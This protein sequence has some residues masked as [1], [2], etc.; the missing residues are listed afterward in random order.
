MDKNLRSALCFF[1]AALLSSNIYSMT[2]DFTGGS[3]S[4]DPAFAFPSL[5]FSNGDV[6][7]TASAG[8]QSS[9]RDTV[10]DS[11][12][13]IWWD[14]RG[15]GVTDLE[16]KTERQR[17]HCKF[18]VFGFCVSWNY[19][20]TV[21]DELQLAQQ[22]D[23]NTRERD[24]IVLE[25]DQE[26]VVSSV[27]L[28]FEDSDDAIFYTIDAG[29]L[30]N[31][32]EAEIGGPNDRLFSLGAQT[33]DV[34]AVGAGYSNHFFGADF[35]PD[36]FYLASI[37][38]DRQSGQSSVSNE[39]PEPPAYLLFVVGIISLYSVRR[40]NQKRVAPDTKT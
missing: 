34:F 17:T 22:D 40:N 1:T 26:V 3:N 15:L 25:F 37:T 8:R 5:D 38:F 24:A 20:V 12:R 16:N 33:G 30:S 9:D 6:S 35:L 13:F 7:V 29:V 31:A 18:S 36:A 19:E 27:S 4:Q 10:S 23:V 21:L 2:I 14:A 28:H 39:I 11:E 32:V